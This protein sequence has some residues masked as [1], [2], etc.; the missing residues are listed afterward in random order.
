M[1]FCPVITD[2]AL[3]QTNITIPVRVGLRMDNST[4]YVFCTVGQANI[5]D[6]L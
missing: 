2:L 3:K 1:S 6:K 4:L 5:I